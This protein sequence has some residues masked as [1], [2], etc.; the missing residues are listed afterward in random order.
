MDLLLDQ[1]KHWLFLSNV[2]DLS[3]RLNAT[4]LEE[5]VPGYGLDEDDTILTY[6]RPFRVRIRDRCIPR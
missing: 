1:P 3:A 2:W 6:S 5:W 4:L